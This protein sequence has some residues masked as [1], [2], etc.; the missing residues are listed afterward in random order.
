VARVKSPAG[1]AR[2]AR[3]M[4]EWGKGE[5]RSGS[6]KGP[7]VKSQKQAEVIALSEARKAG[8]GKR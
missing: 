6:D 3:L 4:H 1:K 2:V 7:K 5:L 8:K